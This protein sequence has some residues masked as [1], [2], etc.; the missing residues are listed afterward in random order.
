MMDL[1]EEE[2]LKPK[3]KKTI[4]GSTLILIAIILLSILC[5]LALM[6]IF[7]I[8]GTILTITLDGI[9]AKEL[10]NIFI[11]E[12]N[13][14]VYMPIKRMAE[15]LRYD[16]FTGDYITRSEDDVNKCYVETDE[17]VVSFTLNSNI[18]TKVIE[19]QSQQIK[20]TE[21][22]KEINGELCIAAEGAQD[23]FNFKFY[24]DANKNNIYIQTLSYLYSWYS[25]QAVNEGYLL[26]E[27]ETY[28]NKAAI[29]D[30]MLIVKAD[31]N[32]YGVINIKG[33]T[34]LETKY[35]SIQYLQNTSDF[36]VGSND[37]KGIISKDKTTKVELTYDS[38]ER[39]TNKNDI[40]YVVEKSNLFGLLDQNGKTIIYPEYEQIGI[41]VSGYSQNGVTN[42]YILYNELVPVKR[43]NKWGLMN[44]NGKKVTDFVYDSFG[45]P[46]GKN[47]LYRTHGVIK[48]LDYNLIVGRQGEKYNLVTLDGKWL[49]ERFI[50]DS[51]YITVS[52]GKNVYYI[53]S[54]NTTKEL[55]SFLQDNGVT[56]PTPIE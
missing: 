25:Q 43:N 29:L 27:E 5:V 15:Y 21:P 32:N 47:N 16:A 24:Y 46:N 55:I 8:K 23:A 7:Y 12:E 45:C 31:N 11:M 54:G 52:E 3:K 36:L 50:L 41:D 17:E 44:I 37:R 13:N 53:T 19:G 49:F 20:I 28:A 4:K 40:F 1:F 33:E 48:V 56:K 30:D 18:L 9:E 38:I 6:A 35:D 51:V 34:I 39:V 2:I 26:I 42:G 14:K 22:I 10:E